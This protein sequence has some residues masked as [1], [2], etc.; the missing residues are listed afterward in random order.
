MHSYPQFTHMLGILWSIKFFS[1]TVPTNSS[2]SQLRLDCLNSGRIHLLLCYDFWGSSWQSGQPPY[3]KCPVSGYDRRLAGDVVPPS[4][5][6]E[7]NRCTFRCRIG[8]MWSGKNMIQRSLNCTWDHS[9]LTVIS[10]QDSTMNQDKFGANWNSI[11]WWSS[12]NNSGNFSVS[13]FCW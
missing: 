5:P 1:D 3:L 7:T 12:S 9:R 11:S 6:S 8:K 2:P 13:A 10:F 4:S